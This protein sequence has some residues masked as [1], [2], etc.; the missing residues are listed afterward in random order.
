MSK[1]QKIAFYTFLL[2]AAAGAF[3]VYGQ[4]KEQ[5]IQ[6]VQ[7]I[8]GIPDGCRFL[9]KIDNFK[10][11]SNSFQNNSLVWQELKR[12]D[13]F[14]AF[15]KLISQLEAIT[16]SNE[17]L[18][19]ILKRQAL[20]I[21]IYEQKTFLCCFNLNQISDSTI[22]NTL[23]KKSS[24]PELASVI[25]KI[26]KGVVILGNSAPLI[27]N[28]LNDATPKLYRNGAF[29]SFFDQ[30]QYKGLAVYC[31]DAKKTEGLSQSYMQLTVSPDALFL[32]G[33][34]KSDSGSFL[35]TLG[36]TG[37]SEIDFLEKI[38]LTCTQFEAWHWDDLEIFEKKSATQKTNWW[39]KVNDSCLFNAQKQ[40]YHAIGGKVICVQLPSKHKALLLDIKDI[41]QYIELES[42]LCDS[43]TETNARIKSLRKQNA[44]FV[45]STFSGMP[46]NEL[47]YLL[48]IENDLFLTHTQEDAEILM[49]A[50]S[51][52][53]SI[54]SNASFEEFAGDHLD[55]KFS[56]LRYCHLN[57]Q[58]AED[59]PFQQLISSGEEK[60]LKNL[61]HFAFV[62]N[63]GKQDFSYRLSIN[64]YQENSLE[65][66]SLLW[67]YLADTNL[68]T[69]PYLFKN[70][71]TGDNELVFQDAN[72]TLYL[73][74]AAGKLIWKKRLNES[75]LSEIHIV[76]AFKKKKYQLLF[77]TENYIHL[78][79]RNGNY[80]QGYPVK[81]PS[82]A[83]NA[84]SVLDYEKKNDLRL[85][86]ACNNRMIYNYSI[87][88]IQQDGFKPF[89]TQT[90][91]R[92]PIHY[93]RVGASDYLATVDQAG[94][95]YAFSRKGE[96]RIDFKTKLPEKCNKILFQEGHLLQNTR[97]FYVDNNALYSLS[98]ADKKEMFLPESVPTSYLFEDVN[99]DKRQDIVQKNINEI[100]ATQ[101]NGSSIEKLNFNPDENTRLI[102]AFSIMEQSYYVSQDILTNTAIV[103]SKA[104]K[105]KMKFKST[106]SPLI[107]DLFRND[108][109]YL[110]AFSDN[111]VK[112]YVL[113]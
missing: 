70:H 33:T 65:E 87:W 37:G 93:G 57:Q 67:T 29:R 9:L 34:L 106:N 12:L 42:F 61:N 35:N 91:V 59:L 100:S 71:N 62:M 48:R 23:L 7:A 84:L 103:L 2:L 107:C 28:Y 38:P 104:L 14:S 76:D 98:F 10:E 31:N 41:K 25:V 85:F 11:V 8:E 73:Q 44:S 92:L 63:A 83:S 89:K 47:N 21:A 36:N 82:G 77:N 109:T 101:L 108:K 6:T 112:V 90:N 81:L 45:Q 69:R 78:I 96:G 53:S 80:V 56:Y 75:I 16:E 97:I 20:Y 68:I 43:V 111:E 54:L 66:P 40:F 50:K 102:G 17:S 1:I 18:S 105:T 30:H 19:E 86:I 27:E 49:N 22:L 32:N 46:C 55:G 110:I 95:V 99:G 15:Q 88:G 3:W 58:A 39:K 74:N 72:K 64:Y 60:K 94:N 4:F 51:N 13:V 79:D 26:N 5:K 113:K 24:A 52:E